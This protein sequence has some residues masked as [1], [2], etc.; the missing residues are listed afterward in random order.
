MGRVNSFTDSGSANK[1]N[2][3]REQGSNNNT[4]SIFLSS[5]SS[6]RKHSNRIIPP[7]KKKYLY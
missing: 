5:N 7:S 6:L 1:F 2:P 4:V 3:S